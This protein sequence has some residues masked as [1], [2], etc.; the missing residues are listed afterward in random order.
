MKEKKQKKVQNRNLN[1]PATLPNR[2]V[3]RFDTRTLEHRTIAQ[4]HKW[5]TTL[6]YL[7]TK[8]YNKH[9]HCV[10]PVKIYSRN[11]NSKWKSWQDVIHESQRGYPERCKSVVVVLSRNSTHFVTIV[12]VMHERTGQTIEFLF[13]LAGHDLIFIFYFNRALLGVLVIRR[14][15]SRYRQTAT[16]ARNGLISCEGTCKYVIESICFQN[17]TKKRSKVNVWNQKNDTWFWKL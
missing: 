9:K 2:D 5:P 10:R 14:T 4:D 13:E 3:I 11:H 8:F 16:I 12:K 6:E 17:K 1:F 15:R 7:I